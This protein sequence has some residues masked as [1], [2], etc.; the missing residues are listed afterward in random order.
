MLLPSETLLRN[1]SLKL[2]EMGKPGRENDDDE[3]TL[4]TIMAK[5]NEM[6]KQNEVLKTTL[7]SK[8]SSIK[9]ELIKSIDSK[10]NSLKKEVNGELKKIKNDYASL[11][12]DVE[13]LQQRDT[14]ENETSPL[15]DVDKC[16]VITDFPDSEK[17]ID[18]VT[19]MLREIMRRD[20]FDA[21]EVLDCKRMG[22]HT[23]ARPGLV[24]VAVDSLESKKRVLR[25]KLK[26][27]E[28][29]KYEKVWMRSSMP[30]LERM[31]HMNMKNMLKMIPGG[32]TYT[33]T[34][35]GKMV[36][37][38]DENNRTGGSGDA[39]GRGRGRGNFRSRGRG[40]RR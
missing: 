5:L 40:G 13:S 7:E 23:P 28:N 9:N 38:Q 37:R 36:P 34:G 19:D 31:F 10:V 33:V 17:L 2:A 6:E 27:K 8:L 39:R 14:E 1:V 4:N 32:D 25:A 35:N 15:D 29:E 30:H 26:A 3:V 11:K 20:E 18:D 12:K 22:R 16:V 24:K 21:I